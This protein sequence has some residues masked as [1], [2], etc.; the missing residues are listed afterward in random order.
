MFR[1]RCLIL[2]ASGIVG[3]RLQQRLVNH[4]MF[5]ICAI[6]GS[7]SSAGKELSDIEWRLEEK[8]PNLPNLTV[9]DANQDD[10]VVL[11][12]NLGIEVAFSGLPSDVAEKIEPKLAHHR[13]MVFS[14]ASA[15][16]METGIP[17]I[18]P[19]INPQ[20]F[21][22]SNHYCATNC[23]LIPLALPIFAIAKLS[24]IK[25]VTMR[26][27]QALSGAGWKL[28]SDKKALSGNVNPYIENEAEKI[29]AEL[30]YLL[31]NMVN[32][33]VS[34]AKI[35]TLINCERVARRDGHQ[36]FVELETESELDID[37]L[38]TQL[39]NLA[40]YQQLPSGPVNA[41]H[42]V[43]KVDVIE[44]LWSD[45]EVFDRNPD[46]CVNLKTG[47]AIVIGDI[48][49]KDRIIS[50]NAYSHNTIRGAAG[51]VV[52]LAEF[53]LQQEF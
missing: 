24:G 32:N 53:I 41:I 50:F 22:R 29:T 43:D 18:I 46:P 4:P 28:L 13:I 39:S 45:G 14:N 51:G 16:R 2:G 52:Y 26:S 37:I 25:S 5:E 44:H 12:Q 36:V 1:R 33:E 7:P 40:S 31:G 48:S 19:E 38:L 30:L 21:Y 3:Q 11:C 35:P 20:H 47:M 6:A 10:L 9:L 27:E 49:I 8:R 17:M 42:V 23:T 34:P 15:Y